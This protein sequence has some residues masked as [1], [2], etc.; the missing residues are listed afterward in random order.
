MWGAPS[1]WYDKSNWEHVL[2]VIFSPDLGYC[3]CA[4]HGQREIPHQFPTDNN[5]KEKNSVWV[6]ATYRAGFLRMTTFNGIFG[7]LQ[8]CVCLGSMRR[9]VQGVTSHVRC[10]L[11]TPVLSRSISLDRPLKNEKGKTNLKLDY[12]P[13]SDLTSGPIKPWVDLWEI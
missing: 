2:D 12:L 9:K 10:C 6:C 5:K 4:F 7:E 8:S 3:G 13:F 11:L 1:A